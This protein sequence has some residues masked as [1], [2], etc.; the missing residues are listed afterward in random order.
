MKLSTTRKLLLSSAVTAVMGISAGYA[1][2][3]FAQDT[4]N[5]QEDVVITTGSRIRKKRQSNQATPLASIGKEDL[6]NT[7]S[8]DVRDLIDNLPINSGSQNNADILTQ[9]FTTGTANV[10]L[11]GL[12]VASTLVLLN[13]RRQVLS[14]VQT[15][16]GSSFVDTSQLIPALAIERTEILKDGA[17]AIYGSDAVAGV[18]NVI[19][20]D[21]LEGAE[22]QA[23]Y[24]TRTDNGNQTDINL[25]GVI[26]GSFGEDGHFLVAASYL[27]RT[28]LNG[29]EVDFLDPNDNS[30]GFGNPATFRGLPGSELGTVPDPQC[31]EFGGFFNPGSA[32]C[33]R[34]F[35]PHLTFVPEEKRFQGFSRVTWDWS[36]KTE[37]WGEIGFA[38]NDIFRGVSTTS[39]VLTPT[40]VPA[41]N[42]GNPFG[43]DVNFLGRAFFPG[44]EDTPEENFFLHETLR[45]AGGAKGE[46]NEKLFWDASFVSAQNDVQL[47][48]RDV[49]VDRFQ[50]S[51]NGFGGFGCTGPN[52]EAVAG[53]G[54][55]FFFNP[56]ASSFN[57]PAGSPLANPDGIRDFLVEDA[58]GDIESTLNAYEVNLT[59]ELFDLP[60]GPIGFAVGGQIREEGLTAV[61]DGIS[62]AD[63]FGFIIGNQNFEGEQTVYAGYG[64]VSIPVTDIIEINGA[65]RYEDYGGEIGSTVDP[66]VSVLVRPLDTLSLRGSYSTSFRAPTVFQNQGV[67]TNFQN[68]TDADGSATFAG[69][70][71]VGNDE[72]QPETSRAFNAGA[73]WEPLDNLEINLDFWDFSFEGVLA[74]A[75]P[76]GI[77]D[78][79]PNDSRVVRSS[80]GTIIL[81]NTEFFNAN[82]IDTNGFDLS[83]RYRLETGFGDI[84]PSF[85]GTLVTTYDLTNSD[86]V[87]TDG[88]GIRNATN[89]GNPTPKFR[90]NWGLNWQKGSHGANVFLRHVSGFTDDQTDADVDA[91]TTVDAQYTFTLSDLLRDDSESSITLGVINA[92]AEDPPFIGIAGNF[93]A[94]TGD[95]RGRR[96]YVR[97]GTK[98]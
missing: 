55:C 96:V 61:Y 33:R 19:T 11:R 23:E 82:G 45:F 51:L 98:F 75:N 62:N 67:Q 84:T 20:R 77:V 81:V 13:G 31:E 38:R 72:L 8:K 95:P 60:A 94:R 27:D 36:D 22:F 59:G 89:F 85:D 88:L 58:L 16:D 17:S 70:R 80:A 64:E 74:Q 47:N 3:A 1:A 57:A 66:K 91:F 87:T 83:A 6:S 44:F 21:T 9:N 63:G 65:L 14:G 40:V 30:S 53:E 35:G 46:F 10:N 24:R 7:G 73:S 50:D 68:I 49:V 78:A 41:S 32:F 52:T 29:L 15:N 12:G 2:P 79:D 34:N 86:G 28:L 97:F 93:D 25:D 69:I 56:F 76:Q 43:E 71:T 4:P 90:G 37:L 26:G 42:P 5:A 18:F 92:T 54:E 48:L 39:P